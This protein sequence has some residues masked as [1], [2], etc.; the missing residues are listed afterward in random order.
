MLV[1]AASPPL[2]TLPPTA[3]QM[4]RGVSSLTLLKLSLAMDPSYSPFQGSHTSSSSRRSLSTP[5]SSPSLPPAKRRRS[6][7][8]EGQSHL[9]RQS[10]MDA[11][12][13]RS[14]NSSSILARSATESSSATPTPDLTVLAT[15]ARPHLSK[16]TARNRFFDA[17][18]SG[19]EFPG[20]PRTIASPDDMTKAELYKCF[21]ILHACGRAT[22]SEEGSLG[23]TRQSMDS[24]LDAIFLDWHGRSQGGDE[25]PI[26][27]FQVEADALVG[28]VCGQSTEH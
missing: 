5:T 10:R 22:G 27:Q 1:T 21:T 6:S 25:K 24:F 9:G 4:P 19:D 11:C 17:L 3:G 15:T 18:E 14:S 8:S 23:V 7:G 12:A 28:R 2:S 13:T 20:K 26:L 16:K